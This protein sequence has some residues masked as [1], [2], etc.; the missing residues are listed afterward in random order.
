MEDETLVKSEL[1]ISATITLPNE[2]VVVAEPLMSPLAVKLPVKLKS[3]VNEI[4]EASPPADWKLSA[5]T[6]PL[7]LISPLAVIL[8]S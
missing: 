1:P 5:K 6:V 4:P 2:P 8:V 3:S 7:A